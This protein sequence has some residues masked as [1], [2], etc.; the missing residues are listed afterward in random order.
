M[1]SRRISNPSSDEKPP[2]AAVAPDDGTFNED[3]P[4]HVQTQS[5]TAADADTESDRMNVERSRSVSAEE[6]DHLK[7][8]MI[9]KRFYLI[10][11]EVDSMEVD[12]AESTVSD[13]KDD[14]TANVV[15]EKGTHPAV[16]LPTPSKD[17][18]NPLESR[19]SECY[20]EIP[21]FRRAS[22]QC[23]GVAVFYQSR[24]GQL[25]GRSR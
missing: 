8:G 10:G 12:A 1:S 19:I 11:T 21:C 22:D 15:D 18:T 2:S 24:C 3:R 4:P 9:H 7:D 25:E 6:K 17:P 13:I 5:D 14:S 20:N 16:Y 23:R